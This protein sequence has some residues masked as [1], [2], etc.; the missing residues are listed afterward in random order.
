M[1]RT[2]TPMTRLSFKDESLCVSMVVIGQSVTSAGTTS[3]L[4]FCVVKDIAGT[5]YTVSVVK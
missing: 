2:P 4:R 1:R 3:T 5:A